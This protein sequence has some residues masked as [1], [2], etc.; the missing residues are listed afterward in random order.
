[1]RPP[2]LADTCCCF[3]GKAGAS[4]EPSALWAPSLTL[5]G[6]NTQEHGPGVWAAASQGPAPP[7][8]LRPHLALS[9][10]PTSQPS[11]LWPSPPSALPILPAEAPSPVLQTFKIPI[12][13]TFSLKTSTYAFLKA[14][15]HYHC[16]VKSL[17]LPLNLGWALFVG[18]VRRGG[19]TI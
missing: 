9:P 18:Q 15:L 7:L 17:S 14:V 2:W 1:M 16:L 3:S 11:Q 5:L 13:A 10:S 12:R 4:P 6:P 19:R 8:L